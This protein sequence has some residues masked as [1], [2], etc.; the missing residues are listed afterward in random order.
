V[1]QGKKGY[2]IVILLVSI[3][4]VTL[5]GVSLFT[6]AQINDRVSRHMA[7]ADR[8]WYAAEAG[9]EWA[10]AALPRDCGE[11]VGYETEFVH[12]DEPVFSV[13]VKP[14]MEQDYAWHISSVG[15]AGNKMRRSEAHVWLWP[16]G[17]RALIAREAILT[18]VGVQGSVIA[19]SVVF[20]PG[21]TVVTG[22]LLYENL[23]LG[24]GWYVCGEEQVLVGHE[25]PEVDFAKLVERAEDELWPS[26]VGEGS[27]R[28]DE[29]AGIAEGPLLVMGDLVLAGGFAFDGVILV[30]GSVDVAGLPEGQVVL[31]VQED[32]LFSGDVQMDEGSALVAW[33]GGVCAYPGGSGLILRGVLFA[34]V[35][36][37]TDMEIVYCDLPAVLAMDAMPEALVNYSPSFG[38]EWL[39]VGT[40][41]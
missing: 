10:I 22:R 25:L 12:L 16:F 6:L 2:A 19:C 41:R 4:L 5:L 38:V 20:G 17:R 36:D 8:A 23:T 34:G 21:E 28:L 15:I 40:R 29:E 18:K 13:T 30:T 27:V 37:L 11:L 33:C 7:E 39:E 35:L 1:K 26:L 32:I 14:S 24:G 31:L 3:S 9:V